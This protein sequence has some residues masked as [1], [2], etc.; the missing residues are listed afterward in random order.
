MT[1]HILGAGKTS[2]QD[3]LGCPWQLSTSFP[4][5][6]ARTALGPFH[7]LR[8]SVPIHLKVK[9]CGPRVGQDEIS[10]VPL[11]GMCMDTRLQMSNSCSLTRTHVKQ[12]HP[13]T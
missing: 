7:F 13:T 9:D 8:P 5:F 10:Y 11:V 12:A 2:Y 1:D 3:Y 6:F 4:L